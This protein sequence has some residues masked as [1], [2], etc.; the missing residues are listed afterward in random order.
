M[1]LIIMSLLFTMGLWA[2]ESLV[3]FN[4]NPDNK[5][6]CKISQYAYKVISQKNAEVVHLHGHDFFKIKDENYYIA[7]TGCYPL[8]GKRELLIF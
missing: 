8:D 3:F 5:V 1:R 2:N 7:K 6:L 4:E